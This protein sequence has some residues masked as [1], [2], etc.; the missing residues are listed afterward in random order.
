MALSG[1]AFQ[2]L[3]PESVWMAN[4]GILVLAGMLVFF[5]VKFCQSFLDTRHNSRLMHN[6]L[7]VLLLL[8]VLLIPLTTLGPH[9]IAIQASNLLSLITAVTMLTVCAASLFLKIRQAG[10][11]VI[12]FATFFLGAVLVVLK[13]LG[14]VPVN[15]ITNYGFQIGSGLEVIL[16]SLAVGNKIRMDTQESNAKI[17]EGNLKIQH[18]N[19]ELLGLNQGVEKKVQERTS[20]LRKKSSEIEAMMNS[21]SIGICTIDG[22]LQIR[23]HSKHMAKLFQNTGLKDVSLTSIL[24]EPSGLSRDN[25]AKIQNTIAAVVGEDEL[26]FYANEVVFPLEIMHKPGGQETRYELNWNPILDDL[27]QVDRILVAI[28]DV[29]DIHQ[30]RNDVKA[31][32]KELLTIGEILN[33]QSDRFQWFTETSLALLGDSEEIIQSNL[34]FQ[35]WEVVLRNIHTIKGNSRTYGLLSLSDVVHETEQ[36][37]FAYDPCRSVSHDWVHV[38]ESIHRIREELSRYMRIN[39]EVLKRTRESRSEKLLARLRQWLFDLAEKEGLSRLPDSGSVLGMLHDLDDLSKISLEEA[40]SPI[41]S[42]LDSLSRQLAKK[43]PTVHIHGGKTVLIDRKIAQTFES[44]FVHLFRNSLDHGFDAEQSGTIDIEVRENQK[45][46]TIR[47]RDDGCGLQIEKLRAKLASKNQSSGPLS[48][49][50]VAHAI[51][52][53]GISSADSVTS[54]SGRGVGMSAV[55]AFVDEL[56]G[57]I[58]LKLKDKKNSDHIQFEFEI[59]VPKSLTLEDAAR[60]SA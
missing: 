45:A 36:V 2:Y 40:L 30:A 13:I 39:E 49:R 8:G 33:I 60:K 7:N 17:R 35:Q 29:T 58:E 57:S 31:K 22:D 26:T 14:V 4:Q 34:A 41:V 44:I 15:F 53:S 47:Y 21:L 6:G 25:L 32:S 24:L 48:D 16:L 55:K 19:E 28:K 50:E 9:K 52:D 12:A 5:L 46:L 59:I 56:G 43:L 37:L 23:Q 1:F 10:F 54:T 27:H 11:F 3:W 20:D 51:F 38:K 42:S 18:L